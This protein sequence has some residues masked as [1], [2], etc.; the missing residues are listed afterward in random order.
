MDKEETL[1]LIETIDDN[2][3]LETGLTKLQ[4]QQ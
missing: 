1:E 4:I 3:I 2:K